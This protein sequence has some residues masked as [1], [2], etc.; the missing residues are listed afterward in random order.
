VART[1]VLGRLTWRVADVLEVRPETRSARTIVLDVPEWPG[2]LAG[3]HVDI[4]L[5]AEDGYT[6]QRS[7]SIANAADDTHLELTVQRVADG[8]VSTYLVDEVRPGDQMEVRGPVGGYFVWRPEQQKPV[9]LLAGG[10]GLVPLMS[11]IRTRSAA[12][13]M[14]PMRLIYSVRSQA[15]VLYA[16]E[17]RRRAD[18]NVG[19]T[20][21][22]V[23]TREAPRESPRPVGRIDAT[24]LTGLAWQ[25]S[26]E[27]INYVC[28]P[29]AFVER[30]AD[31]LVAA[32]HAPVRIRTER[33]G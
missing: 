23:Y 26:D 2:H 31:L 6:A 19:L 22:V 18:E 30:M 5:T 29:T 1:A 16:A 21:T 17:L 32:G 27:P 7:Y 11:M 24:A 14:T 15:D 28:G 33:F 12:Q 10:S 13:V 8:E 3:Q 20:V 9:L 4:R 25:P